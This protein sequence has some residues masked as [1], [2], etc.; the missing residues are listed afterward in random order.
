MLLNNFTKFVESKKYMLKAY[1]SFSFS[2]YK[3]L[4]HLLSNTDFDNKCSS[5]E[6]D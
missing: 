4:K 2:F 6:I 1:T 5:L 3:K